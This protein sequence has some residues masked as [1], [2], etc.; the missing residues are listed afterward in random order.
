MGKIKNPFI[1]IAVITGIGIVILWLIN[2]LLF[3]TGNGVNFNF[4]GNHEGGYFYMGTGLGFTAT[5]ST[6]LL[7]LIKILFILF[8]VGLVI[9]IVIAVKNYVFTEEDIKKIKNTFTSKK[10][11]IIKETCSVCGKTI[12]KEWK[13]CPHCGK[14]KEEKVTVE[15]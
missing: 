1:R 7:F 10:T 6:L 15:A 8:I 11:V 5:I 12:E 9:G 14:L 4:R 13:A 2:A 3:Q